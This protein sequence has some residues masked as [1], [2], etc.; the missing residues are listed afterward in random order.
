MNFQLSSEQREMVNTLNQLTVLENAIAKNPSLGE[1]TIG[2]QTNSKNGLNAC[3]FTKSDGSVSVVFRGT[4][5]GEWITFYSFL[6][7]GCSA[8]RKM[9]ASILF[10]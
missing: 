4:G 6:D 10:Q 2:N 9:R 8:I 7:L 5:S 1:A 3:T